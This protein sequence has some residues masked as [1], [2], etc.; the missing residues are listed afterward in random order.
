MFPRSARLVLGLLGFAALP[1]VHGANSVLT[2]T[3]ATDATIMSTD[4]ANPRGDQTILVGTRG[5]KVQ[6]ILDRGLLRFDL[7]EIPTNA[8]IQSVT[9]NLTVVQV[10]ENPIPS[11]FNLHRLLT[12]WD[13]TASW[14]TA[15]TGT[16]W[17]APGGK[18]GVDY[19]ADISAGQ[20]VDENDLYDFGPTD[21]LKAD[22][23]DW[24]ANP[25]SNH[26]WLM[27]TDSE[28]MFFTARHFGSS[29]SEDPPQLVV[30][31]S[32]GA[33]EGPTLNDV[34]AKNNLFTF[35]FVP[36]P[37][38]AYAVEARTNLTLGNWTVVTNIPAN[39]AANAIVVTNNMVAQNEFFRVKV[40]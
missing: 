9:V 39:P 10:P 35:T 33:A 17:G 21:R 2:I 30:E 23:Q 38:Q 25:A 18:E 7:S 26:G 29:K 1:V 13:E 14:T 5:T 3:S 27:M 15:K 16:P 31:Y 19:S 6:G 8:L 20:E 32:L 24:L 40:Q 34:Q 4:G 11:I 22:V 36:T 37:G 12:A 28:G